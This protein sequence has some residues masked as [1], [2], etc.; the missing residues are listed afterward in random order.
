MAPL[1]SCAQSCADT[2]QLHFACPASVRCTMLRHQPSN[3]APILSLPTGVCLTPTSSYISDPDRCDLAPVAVE[4]LRG[5]HAAM[6]STNGVIVIGHLF[7]PCVLNC[8]KI[9]PV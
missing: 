2:H 5:F 1:L 6:L 9:P 4:T 7:V 8:R 3:L